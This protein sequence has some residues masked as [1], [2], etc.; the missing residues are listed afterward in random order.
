MRR[1][2]YYIPET[3]E[4]DNALD[5]QSSLDYHVFEDAERFD[6]VRP[7]ALREIFSQWAETAPARGQGTGKFA[8]RSQRHDYCLH[9]E[10]DM[11]PVY[12]KSRSKLEKYSIRDHHHHNQTNPPI[13]LNPS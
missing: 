1:L 6:G 9:V 8:M 3:L 13:H 10:V 2:N 5:M 7:S 12:P 11:N 4:F